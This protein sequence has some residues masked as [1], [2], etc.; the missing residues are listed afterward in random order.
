M[1]AILKALDDFEDNDSNSTKTVVLP[2]VAYI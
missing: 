1:L 2:A